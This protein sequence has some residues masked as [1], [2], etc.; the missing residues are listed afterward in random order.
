MKKRFF[1]IFLA[2]L[3]FYACSE[4]LKETTETTLKTEL[5]AQTQKSKW[6]AA[7]ISKEIVQN[8]KK[9]SHYDFDVNALEKLIHTEDVTYI[10]FDLGL[11]ENNQITFTAT[12]EQ[13][14]TGEIKA[15]VSSQI[16]GKD[17][18]KADL[19]IF[20][21]IGN[22]PL[23]DVQGFN[24]ILENTDAYEYI[25]SMEKAYDNFEAALDQEGQRVERF[26]LDVMVVK[27]MLTTHNIH[28]L[29]LFLGKN[30]KQKMTTVFIGKDKK[31]NL[32]INKSTDAS[33]AGKAYD[34]THPCPTECDPCRKCV[35]YCEG[36]WWE[37]CKY[38]PCGGGPR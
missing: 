37:C 27:R 36:S 23:D 24:H 5:L 16:I 9:I 22:I 35:K 13:R 12:G 18:Y 33:T 7:K 1:M 10:W 28:S 32:L 4:E 20:H 14:E 6:V 38:E 17:T 15:Q 3:F 29:A 30:K 2:G 11:N 19:S 8:Q 21:K 34:F 31:G 25:T 26:G